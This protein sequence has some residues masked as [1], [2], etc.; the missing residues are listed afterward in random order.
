MICKLADIADISANKWY[1]FS[2]KTNKV[3]VSVMIYQNNGEI[4]AF[5]NSCPHQ[6]RR[7]DYMAGKFLLTQNGNI[8][9]PAHGAEF[10]AHTGLCI[11]GPCLGQSL[12]PIKVSCDEKSIFAVIK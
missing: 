5:K 2:L 3:L 6:G 9:C 8:V 4:I 1:E 11:N 7:M 12:E 10:N